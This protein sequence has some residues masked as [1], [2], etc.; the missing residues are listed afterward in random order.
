[1]RIILSSSLSRNVYRCTYMLVLEWVSSL[2]FQN[3]KI[4]YTVSAL[5]EVNS[6]LPPGLN[7]LHVSKQL[8]RYIVKD[9]DYLMMMVPCSARPNTRLRRFH[10]NSTIFKISQ[11]W[12]LIFG[13]DIYNRNSVLHLIFGMNQK[14][15]IS[16]D[17]NVN[18]TIF[19]VT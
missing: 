4:F 6:E 1:M 2:T 14:L 17:P 5:R 8:S 15:W 18:L 7:H 10:T 3:W 13:F 11:F 16:I 12:L 9:D 19:K